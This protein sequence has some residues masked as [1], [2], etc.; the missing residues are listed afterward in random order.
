[1]TP[2]PNPSTSAPL[3]PLCGA[4]MRPWLTVPADWLR[5]NIQGPFQLYWCETSQ[6]GRQHP[7]PSPEFIANLY[8]AEHYYTHQIEVPPEFSRPV[9]WLDRLLAHLAWRL[10]HGINL[11]AAWVARYGGSQPIRICEIGCGNGKLLGELRQAGH[12]VI[13]VEP[14][15]QAQ[16][17]AASQFGV[18]VLPGTLEDLP[19]EVARQ[20]YDLIIMSH[21]LEHVVDPALALAN[22]ADLLKPGGK[23]VVETPNSAALGLAWSANTWFCLRV[24]EHLQF[25][26]ERSLRG[27]CDQVGLRV[28]GAEFSNYFRQFVAAYIETEQQ[29]RDC[30]VSR[31]ANP[32][33]LPA[34]N[35]RFRAWRLFLRTCLAP[36]EQRYDCV[37]VIAERPRQ[38][39]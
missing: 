23:L 39:A 8:A 28:I 9:P 21:V 22:A 38:P 25:F 18:T 35:S 17:L 3:C 12:E 10:D 16:H 4:A 37:R 13:G 14:D 6:L 7:M 29:I 1:M 30:F 19:A 33:D 20:P 24:P 27:Y 2:A 5:P 34:R 15:P 32:R 31:G 26:T 11:S 36:V